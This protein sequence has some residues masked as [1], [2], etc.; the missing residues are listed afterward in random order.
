MLLPEPFGPAKT[1]ISGFF[2]T[3]F[4]V[5]HPYRHALPIAPDLIFA[6]KKRA[7]R[8]A[9]MVRPNLSVPP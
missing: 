3:F 2:C 6:D 8:Y 9:K 1:M 4:I 7:K 5:S